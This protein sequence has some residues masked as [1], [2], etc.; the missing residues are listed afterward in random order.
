MCVIENRILLE[1][2]SG[3]GECMMRRRITK[4]TIAL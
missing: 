1:V 4:N 2:I 3:D